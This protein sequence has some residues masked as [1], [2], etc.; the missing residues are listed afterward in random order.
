M[1]LQP[2]ILAAAAQFPE[3]WN[4]NITALYAA[5]DSLTVARVTK[6][7]TYVFDALCTI[8]GAALKQAGFGRWTGGAILWVTKD[9]SQNSTLRQV[10]VPSSPPA[11]TAVAPTC[12]MPAPPQP[13]P[14]A[15]VG[16]ALLDAGAGLLLVSADG[17]VH[18]W[19]WG[20]LKR[21]ASLGA[22]ALVG[23]A[24][25]AFNAFTNRLSLLLPA[26]QPPLLV[27]LDLSSGN[28]STKPLDV[29]C[30]NRIVDFYVGDDQHELYAWATGGS[31]L[32]IYGI[33]G[34]RCSEVITT[35]EAAS[36]FIAGASDGLGSVTAM[37]SDAIYIVDVANN[38]PDDLHMPVGGPN[39]TAF[40]ALMYQDA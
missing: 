13:L 34:G 31:Y 37:A 8:P 16:M 19:S 35:G 10:T 39:E 38:R 6:P 20:A 21:V 15:V 22:R 11:R 25:T 33:D 3:R 32:T 14:F 2:V 23:G 24:L 9:G 1:L 7:D 26:H 29:S 28:H 4:T 5:K 18:T 17:T 36:A 40:V 30:S 27:S 12:K